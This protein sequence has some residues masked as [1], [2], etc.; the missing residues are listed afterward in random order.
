MSDYEKQV[1][2]V[3]HK[4]LNTSDN[5]VTEEMALK[6]TV[7][8]RG[9]INVQSPGSLSTGR[10]LAWQKNGTC[11]DTLLEIK[12]SY[13]DLTFSQVQKPMKFLFTFLH[14]PHVVR[15]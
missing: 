4:H 5:T 15:I 1:M 3:G 10:R 9:Y 6:M 14:H 12:Y 13:V 7:S 8:R 11:V 2:V